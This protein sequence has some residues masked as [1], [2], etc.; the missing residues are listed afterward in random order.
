MAGGG[1]PGEH[2]TEAAFAA[3]ADDFRLNEADAIIEAWS[4]PGR[5]R[6]H[7]RTAQT[8]G[9]LVDRHGLRPRDEA[10]SRMLDIIADRVPIHWEMQRARE[11]GNTDTSQD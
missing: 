5:D 6:I 3:A 9:E 10:I 8:I 7:D 1:E 2:F 11:R 4:T